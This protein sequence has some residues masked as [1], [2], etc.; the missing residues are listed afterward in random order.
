MRL[1]IISLLV[2]LI[3]LFT[4]GMVSAERLKGKGLSR[5]FLSINYDTQAG[6]LV[7]TCDNGMAVEFEGLRVIDALSSWDLEK[8][9]SNVY[10]YK[11]G[12]M[13]FQHVLGVSGVDLKLTNNTDKVMVV[14]WSESAFNLG[15]FSGIPMLPGMKYKDAGNPSATP[16]TIIPPKKSASVVLYTSN[17]TLQNGEWE[18]GYEYVYVDKSLK[19]SV[20]MKVLDPSGAS[21]YSIVESPPIILPEAALEAIKKK[22]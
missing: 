6:S 19:A 14:K 9:G 4:S 21:S 15:S 1:R 5:L 8:T 3:I 10:W 18:E 7:T 17:A 2:T 11:A 12:L 16:D 13:G 22:N 20:Y